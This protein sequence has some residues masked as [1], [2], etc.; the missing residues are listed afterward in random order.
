MGKKCLL[1]TSEGSSIIAGILRLS[2]ENKELNK[3]VVNEHKLHEFYCENVKDVSCQSFNKMINNPMVKNFIWSKQLKKGGFERGTNKV[4]WINY[5]MFF[6]L[7]VDN[8]KSQY[9]KMPLT[10][11]SLTKKVSEDKIKKIVHRVFLEPF[12]IRSKTSYFDLGNV[13]YFSPA[14]W[15]KVY[16]EIL[17]YEDLLKK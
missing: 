1:Y 11:N 6:E 8:M 15:L 9:I 7:G 17:L 10:F 14:D 5:D 13:Y 12:I 2:E 3:Y 16:G 4:L